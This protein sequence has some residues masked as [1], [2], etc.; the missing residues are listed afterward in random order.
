VLHEGVTPRKARDWRKFAEVPQ[1]RFEAA[2]AYPIQKP[3]AAGSDPAPTLF[4]PHSQRW[5]HTHRI[6]RRL[7]RLDQDL[8]EQAT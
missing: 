1:E 8:W 6:T 5:L 3:S 2:L 4:V 7:L